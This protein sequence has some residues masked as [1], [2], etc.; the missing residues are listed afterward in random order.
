MCRGKMNW[1]LKLLGYRDREYRG[2]DF[3]VR[4]KPIAREGVSITHTRNGIRL[5]LGGERIGKKW[6]GIEVHLPQKVD[7]A[8]VSQI[9]RDLETAFRAMRYGYVIAH[10]A[11]MEVVPEAERQAAIAELRDMGYEIEVS[12]DRKQIRQKRIAGAPHSD[13]ETLRKQTSRMMSLMQSVH[14]CRA[15]LE[16]LAR[17]GEF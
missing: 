13:I 2:D 14:G 15:R 1:L 12:T 17:S 4:I 10:L 11:G 16:I 5:D 8:R 7:P 3:S 6:E 9:G